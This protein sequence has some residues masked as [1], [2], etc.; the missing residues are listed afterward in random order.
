MVERITI[1]ELAKDLAGVL[2]RGEKHG[3]QFTIL[4]IGGIDAPIQHSGGLHTCD[5]FGAHAYRCML[6]GW[7][8]ARDEAKSIALGV[9]PSQATPTRNW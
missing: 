4:R 1:E 9:A 8:A 2:D 6:V 3:E 7:R 5:R